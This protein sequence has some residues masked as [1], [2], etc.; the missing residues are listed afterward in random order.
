MLNLAPE[1]FGLV[2][3][4]RDPFAA[5]EH[6]V[7]K[8][9]AKHGHANDI[10]GYLLMKLVGSCSSNSHENSSMHHDEGSAVDVAEPLFEG[11]PA[12]PLDI[13][14]EALG[15]AVVNGHSE[16][17]AVLV[18]AGADPEACNSEGNTALFQ[19]VCDFIFLDLKLENTAELK[20]DILPLL[21][22]LCPLHARTCPY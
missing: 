11:E 8:Q 19:A 14:Q 12:V 16:A 21:S 15:L 7:L 2:A 18:E 20:F 3:Q 10:V 6:Y 1:T 22:T 13:L 4:H 5:D 17:A 9:A